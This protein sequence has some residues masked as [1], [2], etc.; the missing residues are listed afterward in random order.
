MIKIERISYKD[1]SYIR[2]GFYWGGNWRYKDGTHYSA[3]DG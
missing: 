2:R 3:F 1:L